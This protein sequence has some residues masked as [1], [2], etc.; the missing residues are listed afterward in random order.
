MQGAQK[1]LTHLSISTTSNQSRLGNYENS[2]NDLPIYFF[3][4]MLKK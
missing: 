4:K 1:S 3:I 2:R